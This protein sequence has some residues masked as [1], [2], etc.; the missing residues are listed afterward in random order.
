MDLM[1][2]PLSFFIP[3]TSWRCG[4]LGGGVEDE[5]KPCSSADFFFLSLQPEFTKTG[6]HWQHYGF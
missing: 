5:E 2:I 6:P 3:L 1:H 4:L